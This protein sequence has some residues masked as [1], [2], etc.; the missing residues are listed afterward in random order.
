[1]DYLRI[2]LHIV[3]WN[4]FG[5]TALIHLLNLQARVLIRHYV[6]CWMGLC[7]WR[8]L[9]LYDH[10][11]VFIFVQ[12]FFIDKLELLH[13]FVLRTLLPLIELWKY[14]S[15]QWAVELLALLDHIGGIITI[16]NLGLPW[17]LPFKQLH[18]TLNMVVATLTRL[19]LTLRTC[20]AIWLPRNLLS[21]AFA[22][23]LRRRNS[24]AALK[25]G[26]RRVSSRLVCWRIRFLT[27]FDT[28]SCLRGML[29]WLQDRSYHDKLN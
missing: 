11:S 28:C 19:P 5:Q 3:W 12:L 13:R 14:L 22:A 9:V 25:W 10:A 2:I 27:C 16:S 7:N 4:I 21:I 24:V 29:S 23:G 1:M 20:S 17:P 15:G 26:S 6:V 8:L 18:L